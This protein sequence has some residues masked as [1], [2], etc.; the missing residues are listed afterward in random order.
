MQDSKQV[1]VL[2]FWAS[3]LQEKEW[4]LVKINKPLKTISVKAKSFLLF[5]IVVVQN[6]WLGEVTVETK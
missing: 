6:T 5:L 4:T 1:A 2:V 3:D